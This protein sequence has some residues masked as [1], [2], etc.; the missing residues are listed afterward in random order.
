MDSTVIALFWFVVAFAMFAGVAWLCGWQPVDM[1][2]VFRKGTPAHGDEHAAFEGYWEKAG[3]GRSK[4]AAWAAWKFRANTARRPGP[5]TPSEILGSLFGIA[6]A[7]LL[8]T[9]FHPAWGF[10]AFLVSNLGWIA[11]SATLRHR[12]LLVQQLF[13]LGSSLIG[14]WNWWLGPLVLG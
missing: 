6:G 10:G 5:T 11:F 9:Q 1:R 2:S 4:M 12:W 8:A 7:W 14:L 3:D 13:F